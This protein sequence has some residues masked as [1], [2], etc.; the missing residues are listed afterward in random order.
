M[1]KYNEET[2]VLESKSGN[3]KYL[4]HRWTQIP[5]E[6]ESMNIEEAENRKVLGIIKGTTNMVGLQTKDN[7]SV[8]QKWKKSKTMNGFFTLQEK[9]KKQYLTVD[10]ENSDT[11]VIQSK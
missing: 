7:L 1:W 10:V 6:N 11:L 9:N 4:P 2:M 5:R 8:T 3:W